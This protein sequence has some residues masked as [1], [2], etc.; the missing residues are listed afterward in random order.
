L[1]AANWVF[2][3]GIA[4]RLNA[5]LRETRGYTYGAYS[6]VDVTR[7][8]GLLSISMDVETGVT[9]DAVTETRRELDTLT[10]AGLTGDEL[11]RAKEWMTRSAAT[12]FATRTAI[13]DTLRG[14]YLDDLPVDYYQTRPGRVAGLTADDVAAVARRR[15]DPAA[16]T[17]VA[18]GDRAAVEEPLRT[19]GIGPVSLRSP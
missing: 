10:D 3:G 6:D 14:I 16:F 7:G 1:L 15:F 5:N 13:L 9:A 2:G 11:G 8:V 17:V 18:V 4:S 19:L 12:V